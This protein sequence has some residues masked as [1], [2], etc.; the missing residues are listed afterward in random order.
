MPILNERTYVKC[1]MNMGVDILYALS[2][3]G[4]VLCILLLVPLLRPS[5]FVICMPSASCAWA[6]GMQN[7]FFVMHNI[8]LSSGRG[9]GVSIFI[10][11]VFSPPLL[12]SSVC[13]RT[14]AEVRH[15][16]C[17]LRTSTRVTSVCID[18]STSL[19]FF[20]LF[21]FAIALH[22]AAISFPLPLHSIIKAVYFLLLTTSS[23]P[24][25]R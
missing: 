11:L 18:F 21:K 9:G 22:M 12:P 7:K 19:S 3:R 1:I 25:F 13:A 17:M 20:P 23:L 6:L 5:G 2:E 14:L 10:L 8:V 24:F 4:S 16:V 15:S